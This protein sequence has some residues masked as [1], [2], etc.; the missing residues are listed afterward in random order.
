MMRCF[1]GIRLEDRFQKKIKNVN[2]FLYQNGVRG[3]FTDINNVHLTLAFIGEIDRNIATILKKEMD[4][5]DIT[6]FSLE[7]ES[8]KEFKSYLILEV[9]K[10]DKLMK[11]QKEVVSVLQKNN[12]SFD[13]KEYYPHITLVRKP[14][15]GNK[16]ILD[17][18]NK[19]IK[20]SSLVTSITTFESTRREKDNSLIYIAL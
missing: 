5:I 13:D 12:I 14:V 4:K 6:D 2:Q 15:I 1:I 10:T 17:D 19:N 18:I 7:I 11:V 20:F 3:N 16:R 8:I 9:K